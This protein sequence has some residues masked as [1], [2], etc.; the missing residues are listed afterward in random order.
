MLIQ[1]IRRVFL[2][3]ASYAVAIAVR[4]VADQKAVL[5]YVVFGVVVLCALIADEYYSTVRPTKRI[6]ELAP[7][8]LDSVAAPLLKQ[9]Q[10]DGIQARLNLMMPRRTWRWCGLYRYFKI[11]WSLGMENQPDVNLSFRL[12]HGITG[13][14]F[15][16]KKPVYSGPND[17][18]RPEFALPQRIA[19]HAPALQVIFSYPVYEP[20]RKDHRQSGRVIGV[21]NLDSTTHNAYNILMEAIDGVHVAMQDIARVAARFYE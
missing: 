11:A 3:V 15:R 18:C 2:G 8:A 16:T 6:A 9:L 5:V 19:R 10:G 14:C 13:Q 12:K 20:A 17:I 7:L 21:L 4:E 1:S